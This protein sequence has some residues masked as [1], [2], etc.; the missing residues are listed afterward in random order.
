MLSHR[1][2]PVGRAREDGKKQGWDVRYMRIRGCETWGKD[3]GLGHSLQDAGSGQ[4]RLPTSEV[5]M[6]PGCL[7]LEFKVQSI[8]HSLPPR[9]VNNDQYRDIQML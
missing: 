6:G 4:K 7:N 3:I 2:E 1:V 9:N 5:N 8:S